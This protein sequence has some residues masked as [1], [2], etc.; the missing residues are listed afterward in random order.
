MRS[1]LKVILAAVTRMKELVGLAYIY[2]SILLPSMCLSSVAG[3]K[4]SF[5]LHFLLVPVNVAISLL[6]THATPNL[7]TNT[8]TTF[9]WEF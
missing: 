2:S 8:P 9:S 6:F 5:D 3:L 4:F 1:K 7:A